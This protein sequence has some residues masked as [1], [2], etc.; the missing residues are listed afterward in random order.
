[1]DDALP[2]IKNNSKLIKVNRKLT[3]MFCRDTVYR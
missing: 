3:I 2:Q 1:V